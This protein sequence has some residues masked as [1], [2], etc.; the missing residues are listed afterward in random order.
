MR[1]GIMASM[2]TAVGGVQAD[3]SQLTATVKVGYHNTVK[4][5]QWM[6]VVI[7]Y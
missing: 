6:P 5:G 3:G 7:D 2:I 1:M 4:Q